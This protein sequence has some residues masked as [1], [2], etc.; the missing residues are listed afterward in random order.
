MIFYLKVAAAIVLVGAVGAVVWIIVF[1]IIAWSW[2]VRDGMLSPDT[3]YLAIL[4]FLLAVV[5]VA[6][7]WSSLRRGKKGDHNG[8]ADVTE[9]QTQGGGSA[10][11]PNAWGRYKPIPLSL[12]PP[13]QAGFFLGLWEPR[14][15]HL[16]PR[17]A[18]D[19]FWSQISIGKVIVPIGV[20]T[21]RRGMIGWTS[22]IST[23]GA[24]WRQP[25]FDSQRHARTVLAH[26]A[27]AV[28]QVSNAPFLRMRSV[29]GWWGDAGC[30]R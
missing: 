7:L 10:S 28:L 20:G 2:P 24:L 25:L 29:Y 16:R 27:V 9:T 14:S 30:W 21:R 15:A 13:F 8:R 5:I 26:A 1:A 11:L 6:A 17:P 22:A 19:P 23:T 18:V 12:S 3:V 4:F